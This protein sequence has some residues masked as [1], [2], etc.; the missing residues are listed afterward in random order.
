MEKRLAFYGAYHS[1]PTN[2]T[3]HL[4]C[5]P[6][7]LWSAQVVLSNIPF[8]GIFGFLS[9]YST[10]PLS[11][12]LIFNEYLVYKFSP[13]TVLSVLFFVYY[14]ILEPVAAVL[15]IPQLTFS[16][17]TATAFAQRREHLYYAAILHV[18]CWGMQF[19]GHFVAEKRAPALFDDLLGALVLAPLFVHLENLFW[20]GYRPDL[21]RVLRNAISKDVT[22]FRRSHK[23]QVARNTE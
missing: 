11:T 1:N 4:I 9:T 5:V 13:A 8:P 21:R 10:A 12:V 15:Y 22:E 19:L 7:I 3:I 18:F 2:L 20:L 6:L 16:L 17:L 23:A 14:V